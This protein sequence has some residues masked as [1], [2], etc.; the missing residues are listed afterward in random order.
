MSGTLTKYM[1]NAPA[2][3]L[4]KEQMAAAL[5]EASDKASTGSGNG[6]TYLNFSGKTGAYS[7]GADKL[8]IDPEDMFIF[9]PS[10]AFEGF[11]CWKGSKPVDKFKWSIYATD[12]IDEA[13]LPD[14]SP[15]RD[16]EGWKPL[17]GICLLST[18]GN[19][20][21]IE[22]STDSKSGRN[23]LTGLFNEIRDRTLADEPNMPLVHFEREQF[24]ANEQTNWKPK[25]VIESW[26]SVEQVAAFLGDEVTYDLND[27]VGGKKLTAGQLK[28]LAA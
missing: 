16:N 10:M 22:F 12:E 15:Y 27:L 21:Q 9:D 5:G 8:N 2:L 24:T 23:A 19:A 4:S 1:S 18:D 17:L 6:T 28:K 20:T 13:D 25:F 3:K 14:H 26:A 11:Q 7:L